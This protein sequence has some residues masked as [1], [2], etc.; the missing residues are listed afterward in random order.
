MRTMRNAV[1]LVV[2]GL[3]CRAAGAGEDPKRLGDLHP[4]MVPGALTCAVIG[5]LPEGVLLKTESVQVTEKDLQAEVD[6]LPEALRDQARKHLPFLL[7]GLATGKLLMEAARKDAAERKVDLSGKL[8]LD[9]LRGFFEPV[10]SGVKV[11]KAE[12]RDFFERNAELFGG[13]PFEKVEKELEQFALQQKKEQAVNAVVRNLGRRI[14][15]TVSAAWLKAQVP[16]CRDNPVD[17]ARFG[18]KPSLVDFGGAGCCGPDKMQPVI[19]A[20]GERFK[21][22]LAVL[23]VEAR[24]EPVLAARYGINSIPA[25]I[26]FDKDGKEVFRHSGLMSEEEIAAQLK[27]VGIK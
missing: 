25:Q 6:A 17:K 18:G 15:I 14:A 26:L 13:A 8:D 3:A 20:V 23:Y 19:E 12:L 22:S 7:E 24:S 4:G 2:A 16:L 10:E 11:D 1:L 9:I 27:A 5:E 21:D